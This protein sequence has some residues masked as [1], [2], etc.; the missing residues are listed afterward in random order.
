MDDISI[1]PEKDAMPTEEELAG[2]LDLTYELWKRIQE[3][4]LLKY[5]DGLAEWNY[6]GKKYGWNYRIKDKKRAIIY[7]LPR[8]RYFK[9]AFVF[10]DKAMKEILDSPVSDFIKDELIQAKKYA[11]GRGISMDV[12]HVSIIPDITQLIEIKLRN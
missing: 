9:V 4:V 3:L 6:P 10:G 5:P 8:E 1:F 7:L 11:E 12:K 2:S